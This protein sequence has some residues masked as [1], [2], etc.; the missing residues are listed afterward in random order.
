M[1]EL[2]ALGSEHVKQLLMN[3]LDALF[4][5]H[6]LQVLNR[7]LDAHALE[8][9]DL[10]ARD[11][12]RQNFVLFRRGEDENDV[13]R[14]FFECLEKGVESLRREHVHLVND[15]NFVFSDLR[16]D[17]RLFHQRLDVF[18]RVVRR[19]VEFEN[20]VRSLFVERLTRLTLV[21][22]LALG[23]RLE[24]VD[25]LREDAC[26]GCFSDATRSVFFGF[27]VQS[28]EKSSDFI[29]SESFFFII[30][31]VGNDFT[32]MTNEFFSKNIQ[33]Y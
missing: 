8:I 24:A 14:R 21:A 33:I 19:G 3:G 22:G 1:L 5:R 27:I 16:R 6:F 4:L 23:S 13:C 12:R 17:A 7:V 18:H 20:V 29:V 10:A 15:E 31:A 26:A 2:A 9:V 28:Y 25:G 30:F 11:N 32:T